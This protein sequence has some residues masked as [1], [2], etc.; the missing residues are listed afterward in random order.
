MRPQVHNLWQFIH[1]INS[2]LEFKKFLRF[3]VIGCSNTIVSFAVYIMAIKFLPNSIG[4]T[5]VAQIVSYSA[6]ILWSFIWN[7]LWVFQS[8]ER[9]INEGFRFLV[10]QISLLLASALMIG[11][12]VDIFNTHRIW[13]WI[14]V[15][16]IIT[17]LNYALLKF[18]AFRNGKNPS[19]IKIQ[20]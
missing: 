3:L 15:M 17:L 5:S 20:H 9:V 7:R 2:K 8:K 11:L 19:E 18:W 1:R 6:G 14:I 4:M 10:V 16:A 13:A 12:A